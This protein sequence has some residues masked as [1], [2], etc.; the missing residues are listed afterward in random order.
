MKKFRGKKK[1]F[2]RLKTHTVPYE[3]TNDQSEW[4]DFWHTHYDWQGVGNTNWKMRKPHLDV[5]FEHFKLYEQKLKTFPKPFQLF[6]IL[7]DTDSSSDAIYIH[8][9]NE[10]QNNFPFKIKENSFCTLK[11]KQLRDFLESVQG[12]IK[13]FP[14]PEPEREGVC[15]LYKQGTGEAII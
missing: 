5:L 1:Y 7:H 11:N 15:F 6:I 12:F 3:I 14:K 2:T 13:I 10:N 8:Q 9:E 4:F